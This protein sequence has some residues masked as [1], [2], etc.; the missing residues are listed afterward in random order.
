MMNHI[1]DVCVNSEMRAWR[2][3][4]RENPKGREEGS[5]FTETTSRNK[6]GGLDLHTTP[7]L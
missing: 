1:V 7:L 4:L 3:H 6:D 5:V 2:G